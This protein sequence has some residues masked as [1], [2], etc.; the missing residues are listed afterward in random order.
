MLAP[1]SWSGGPCEGWLKCLKELALALR[2]KRNSNLFM[3]LG[4]LLEPVNRRQDARSRRP[5][6]IGRDMW[7]VNRRIRRTVSLDVEEE[8][9]WHMVGRGYWQ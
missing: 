5:A 9:L 6:G 3:S 2:G 8:V 4:V 7:T 1:R